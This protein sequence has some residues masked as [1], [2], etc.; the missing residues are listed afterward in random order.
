MLPSCVAEMLDQI[1]PDRDS[2]SITAPLIGVQIR[3]PGNG[4]RMLT[5]MRAAERGTHVVIPPRK[6]AGP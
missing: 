3:L 6:N 1:P 4:R 2:A 5:G